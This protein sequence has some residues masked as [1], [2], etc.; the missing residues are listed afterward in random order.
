MKKI[1]EQQQQQQQQKQQQQQQQQQQQLTV[2]DTDNVFY[3]CSWLLPL[4][5]FLFSTATL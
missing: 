1:I 5:L 4:L 3:S 2:I